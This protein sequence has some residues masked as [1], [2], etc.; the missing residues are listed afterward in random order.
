MT[1]PAEKDAQI[2]D[3]LRSVKRIALVGASPK[4]ERPSHRV[5]G[6]LLSKGYAVVPVNPG[7]A[8]KEIH[9]ETV[10][11]SLAAIP[12]AIDMVDIFRAS[13]YVGG[14]VDEAL[15]LDPLPGVIWMQLDIVDEEAAQRA[16][17]RGLDVV[18]D[19]CPAIEYPRLIG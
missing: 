15:A 2:R 14:V 10:Y 1:Q 19:R 17:A 4:P 8:G 5:M 6:F 11:E 16:R 7:L 3:I 13:E 18:M 9:G 12:G